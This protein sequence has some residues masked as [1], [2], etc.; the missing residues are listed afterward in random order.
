MGFLTSFI[1]MLGGFYWVTYVIHE[2]GYLPW[3]ISALLFLG[4]CGFGAL[5][6]PLF[7]VAAFKISERWNPRQASLKTQAI[8]QLLGLPALFTLI[9]WAI[10]KLFPWYLGHCLY[11]FP[12]LIQLSDTTGT[13]FLT[14]SLL[15]L[16]GLFTLAFKKE[17]KKTALRWAVI[18]LT[19]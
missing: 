1:V 6:F 7:T 3:S 8:W 9:E 14:F 4:F 11:H 10:P 13:L 15:S 5:N 2:F 16:G 12:V 18:P 19:L 17:P